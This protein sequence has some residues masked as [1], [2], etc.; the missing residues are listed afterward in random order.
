M[1]HLLFLH[2]LTG[3]FCTGAFL[4]GAG[5]FFA[6]S[7]AAA[8]ATGAVTVVAATPDLKAFSAPEASAVPVHS[9]IVSLRVT[10][11]LV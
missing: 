4:T 5:A 8:T 3:G 7:G 9:V 1:V 11:K 2:S 10:M 6:S